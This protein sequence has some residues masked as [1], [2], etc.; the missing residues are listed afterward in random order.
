MRRA[1]ADYKLTVLILFDFSKAFDSIP[2]RKLLK[3]F[4]LFYLSNPVK[5]W[6]YSYLCERSS[7]QGSILGPLLF[8]LY[9]N[10]LPRILTGTSHA[11]YTDDAQIYQHFS[12]A[13]IHE[14]IKIMQNNA[15]VVADRSKENGLE[16]NAAK[17]KVMVLD[18][19]DH[20]T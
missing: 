5:T 14:G 13:E 20:S 10:D 4:R 1:I 15:Q 19:A 12:I 6:I 11:L 7:T 2:H 9:I 3:K 17:T 18:S 16:L 8:A